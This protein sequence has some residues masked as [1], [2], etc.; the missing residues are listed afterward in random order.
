VFSGIARLA[1]IELL[2]GCDNPAT[3]YCP[4]D[5][6]V[7]ALDIEVR[8]RVE[9]PYV[10][11]GIAGAFGPVAAASMFHDGWRPDAMEGL[12][13]LECV[14]EGLVLAPRQ[15]F[16]VRFALYAADGMTVLYPK[17][18]VANFITGGSA[19]ACG[20][21]GERAEGRILGAPPILCSYRWRMPGGIERTWNATSIMRESAQR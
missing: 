5:A 17:R 2:D 9:R 13:H 10:L 11:I 8:E 18:A 12:Y 14:F 16:T 21:S 19:A 7:L 4:G 20:F 1:G 3:R 6:I 15:F